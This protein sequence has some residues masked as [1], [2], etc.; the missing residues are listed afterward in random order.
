MTDERI[1]LLKFPT[2]FAIG[3]TERHVMN[4]VANLD[5]ARFDLRL[6]CLK[7]VGEFLREIEERRVPL[8]DY[9]IDRLYGPR[10]L[11]QQCRFAAD[12]RRDRIQIVHTYGF[13]PNVFGIAAAR[14]AGAD[15]V[16]ASI[17]D[18]GVY[19][20]A[21]QKRAQKLACR[22]ADLVLVN[23]DA[24]KRTLIDEGY[25]ADRIQVIRNGVSPNAFV[26]RRG[27]ARLRR[28]LGIPPD[29]P[30]VGMLSRLNKLKGVDDFLEAA[31]RVVARVPAARFLLIGDGVMV[32]GGRN[33][34][35]GSYGE[36]LQQ[37]AQQLGLADRL[38]FTGF[39]LDVPE[40]L[41]QCDVSVLPSHSEGLSNT[42][43]ESMAAGVPVVATNV[44]GNPE[45]VQ[46]GRTG[47]L[48]S[49]KNAEALADRI[50]RLLE[51][52]SLAARFGDTGRRRAAEHFS[53]HRMLRD[54]E[55]LYRQLLQSPRHLRSACYST[56]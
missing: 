42:L 21:M 12:V 53:I 30:V 45:V 43:L 18:T 2:L 19:L 6:A 44:G 22:F 46:E 37:T 20:S 25:R 10:A 5:S 17:R 48:V 27:G 3:G 56:A 15:L 40:L 36:S 33:A 9:P 50:C 32:S 23:A 39:R 31:T 34:R 28:Q 1:R 38:V 14:A 47:F 52:R 7:R 8:R 29:A 51:D 4:F 55:D 16:I 49:P 13:Y 35:H 24:I 11:V 41:A 26:E 54:T